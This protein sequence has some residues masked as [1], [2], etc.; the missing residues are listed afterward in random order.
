MDKVRTIFCGTS[1][2]AVPIFKKLLELEYI[3]LVGVVTQPD[4][5]VGRKQILTAPPVKA[6]VTNSK[7]QITNILQPESLKKEA[8][9]ILNDLKPELIIVAS[10]G[11]F[12]PKVMLD[13]PRYKCLNIHGSLLPDLRGAIPVQMAIMKGYKQTGVSIQIMSEGMDEGDILGYAKWDIANN[14]TT[15]TLMQNL[16]HLSTQLLEEILPKWINGEIAPQQQDE[17][18]ATYCY[19]KDISKDKAEIDWNRSAEEIDQLIRA[20]TGWTRLDNGKVFKIY[21]AKVVESNDLNSEIGKLTKVGK[22]LF[23]KC[24]T[25]TLELIEVQLEGK[26]KGSASEYL[27]LAT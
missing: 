22:Q 16:S 2:F 19:I 17:S 5:L 13:Y 15:D 18:N 27:Y 23:I 20:I 7:L 9:S 14:E 12:I 24:G 3:D 10:Y 1:E 21:K 8:E 25:K 26:N 6:E 4:R 11:Q